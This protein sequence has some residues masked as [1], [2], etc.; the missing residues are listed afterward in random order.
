MMNKY[1][2]VYTLVTAEFLGTFYT[3]NVTWPN[4]PSIA[5]ASAIYFILEPHLTRWK[6]NG[7]SKV[8]HQTCD[9]TCKPTNAK[10]KNST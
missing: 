1:G 2:N 7:Y 10:V 3:P 4:N 5:K 8:T 6:P 9:P